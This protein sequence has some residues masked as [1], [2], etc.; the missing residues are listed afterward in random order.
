MV[1]FDVTPTVA[2]G[3]T[4]SFNVSGTYT[5]QVDTVT[6]SN[7]HFIGYTRRHSNPDPLWTAAEALAQSRPI[8]TNVRALD[9]ER[10]I[11]ANVQSQSSNGAFDL[12]L[13]QQTTYVAFSIASDVRFRFSFEELAAQGWVVIWLGYGVPQVY[14]YAKGTL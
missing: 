7:V 10:R 13:P 1:E 6:P 4:V 12:L 8:S 11:I 3:N 9:V 5:I 2:G 14:K